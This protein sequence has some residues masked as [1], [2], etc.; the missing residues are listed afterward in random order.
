MKNVLVLSLAAVLL[1][2]PFAVYGGEKIDINKA[3]YEKGLSVV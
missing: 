2:V 1:I 3:V